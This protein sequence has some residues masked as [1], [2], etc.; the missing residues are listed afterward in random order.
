MR[1][2]AHTADG[3]LVG[4]FVIPRF[5]GEIVRAADDASP[6]GRGRQQ[7]DTGRDAKREVIYVIHMF[8]GVLGVC[9]VLALFSYI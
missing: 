1:R 5:T 2:M 9:V 8:L 3:V 7:Q 6:R 4:G